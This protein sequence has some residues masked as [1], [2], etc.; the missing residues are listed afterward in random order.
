MSLAVGMISHLMIRRLYA[1]LS[2]CMYWCQSL[3]IKPEA[4]EELKFWFSQIGLINGREI[5]HSPLALR[6]VYSDAS[7]SGYGGFTVEHS[8]HVAHGEWSPDKMAQSSTWR[9]LKA[10]RMTLESLVSKLKNEQV[11][12]FSDNQKCS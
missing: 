3:P 1:L 6:V 5:W 11:K 8:C 7:A 9:E 2:S 12:W 10:V 4:R